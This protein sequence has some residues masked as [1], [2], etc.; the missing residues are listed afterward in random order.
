MTPFLKCD[1]TLADAL[2]ARLPETMQEAVRRCT[3]RVLIPLVHRHDANFHGLAYVTAGNIGY[4]VLFA[5]FVLFPIVLLTL[6]VRVY[7]SGLEGH[8]ARTRREGMRVIF[9]YDYGFVMAC[10]GDLIAVVGLLM[11]LFKIG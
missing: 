4:A 2:R 6:L 8:Q 10:N 11:A 3:L 9:W 7:F 1:E 5:C